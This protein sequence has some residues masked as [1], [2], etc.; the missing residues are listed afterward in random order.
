MRSLVAYHSLSGTT[1]KV[2]ERAARALAAD[3]AEVR[4][5]RYTRG[6]LGFMRAGRDSWIGRL[7][8]IEVDGA[9]PEGYDF[10]LVMGPV[11]VGHAS[12]PIRAYLAQ[13]RGKFRRL[14]L[15]L[16][17]GNSASTRAFQEMSNL[18]GTKPDAVF[19]MRER[20]IRKQGTLPSSLEEFIYSIKLKD[21]A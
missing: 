1:R 17:C 7:P 15:V 13:N 9:P 14:A 3:L 16:T 2:A 10:V 12:T 21:A 5:P 18:A 4:T 6:L 20:D 8:P 11:W 19:A